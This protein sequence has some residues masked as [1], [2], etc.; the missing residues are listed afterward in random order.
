MFI[1][2]FCATQRRLAQL[3]G[4]AAGNAGPSGLG[5]GQ[6]QGGPE[7]SIQYILLRQRSNSD[8]AIHHLGV[9]VRKQRHEQQKR[10]IHD[11]LL[12][13]KYWI[14]KRERGVRMQNRI[15]GMRII[16]YSD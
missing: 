16:M 14:H 13:H 7:V 11:V 1:L 4:G 2:S 8:Y 10:K 6:E 15:K 12:C 9:C 3:S 5:G